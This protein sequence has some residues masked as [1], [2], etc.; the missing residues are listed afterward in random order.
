[1]KTIGRINSWKAIFSNNALFTLL[2]EPRLK[3]WFKEPLEINKKTAI[4]LVESSQS[5]QFWRGW[6]GTVHARGVG[7]ISLLNWFTVAP[8][9]THQTHILEFGTTLTPSME[10]EIIS[11][12][13]YCFWSTKQKSI[14]SQRIPTNYGMTYS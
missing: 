12:F 11:F 14:F 6:L 5:R 1:M 2:E 9:G 10:L 7:D 3:F 8:G 13:L 4:I